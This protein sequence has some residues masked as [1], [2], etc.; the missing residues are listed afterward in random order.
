MNIEKLELTT[1]K[2]Y[3]V[4]CEVLDE[5]FKKS[6]HSRDSQL[7]EWSRYFNFIK[8]GHKITVTEI[9]DTVK[10]K[11]DGRVNNGHHVNSQ[12]A[13][14]EN[15]SH[16]VIPLDLLYNMI[17][18]YHLIELASQN[19]IS[20]LRLVRH[21]D[22]VNTCL[23]V[24][25]QTLFLEL[26][27]CHDYT[28]RFMLSKTDLLYNENSPFIKTD[29][30]AVYM[31]LNNL[32]KSIKSKVLCDYVK[33]VKAIVGKD[34]KTRLATDDE[35]ALISGIEQD[36]IDCYNSEYNKHLE[37]YG[38]IYNLPSEVRNKIQQNKYFRLSH[39]L[40]NYNYDCTMLVINKS[41]QSD[42][43]QLGLTVDNTLDTQVK[44]LFQQLKQ[45]IN[46]IFLFQL[47]CSYYNRK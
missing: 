1:Y 33:Q 21:Q 22:T 34:Y 14:E 18:C 42:I 16:R 37:S 19:D 28:S 13:L 36:L 31:V 27:F 45:D 41:I 26:G 29:S 6:G 44:E 3:K 35:L 12:Q 17:S 9:Y 20:I 15:R 25:P 30:T 10:P 38:D 40:E 24:K 8:Q 46:S 32:Y 11:V 43:E 7:K 39:Q 5:P 47:H 4:V 2:N 23:E